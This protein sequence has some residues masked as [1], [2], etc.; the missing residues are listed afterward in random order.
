[1]MPPTL[2]TLSRGAIKP[3][4]DH[5]TEAAA[6]SPPIDMLIQNSAHAVEVAK[7][8]PRIPTPR[9]V[10]PTKTNCR[11]RTEFRPARTSASTSQPPTS[12]S[13][14]VAKSH[15]TPVYSDECDGSRCIEEER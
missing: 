3:G 14:Q 11:T 9:D 15:G 4:I 10:P 1:M 5:P 13:T 7:A 8:A 12:S 2:P 6:D